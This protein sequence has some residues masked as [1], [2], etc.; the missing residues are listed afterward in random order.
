MHFYRAARGGDRLAGLPALL[1]GRLNLDPGG[2][3]REVKAWMAPLLDL[4]GGHFPP[5]RFRRQYTSAGPFPA[6]GAAVRMRNAAYP[7]EAVDAL[8][9]LAR[10]LRE[11]P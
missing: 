2:P 4:R 6:S 9:A 10:A 8:A 1:A 5:R 11:A 3:M 7:L